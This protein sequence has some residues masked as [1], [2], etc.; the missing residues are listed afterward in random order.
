[1][2]NPID[3]GGPAVPF[4]DGQGGVPGMTLRDYFAGQAMTAW[5]EDFCLNK[6]SVEMQNDEALKVAEFCYIMANAMIATRKEA[7]S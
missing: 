4:Y 3:D 6:P 1:M 5:I 2:S 7:Q